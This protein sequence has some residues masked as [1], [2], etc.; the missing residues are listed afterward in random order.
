MELIDMEWKEFQIGKFFNI[1]TGGDVIISKLKGGNIPVIS[2]SISN[3]GVSIYTQPIKGKKLF[4]CNK[5]ISLADRGNFYAYV[6][7]VDFYIG[8]RVKALEIKKE[9]EDVCNK[10]VLMFICPLINAQSVKFSYG[11]NC[12]D[13]TETLKIL[14]P[15]DEANNPDWGFMESYIKRVEK[16]KKE[17]YISYLTGV[18]KTLKH[19]SI[20]A[21]EDKEWE[22]FML[23]ELF[24]FIQ[25]GKR[26]TKGNQKPGLIPYVSS[27]AMNNGVDNFI[28][29]DK[30]VR[31]FKNCLS[32]ANSG[33]VGS[34]FYE[35]YEFVASDHV[36]HLKNENMNKYIYIFIATIVNRLSEKYNFNREINDFRISREKIIL[37]V[38]DDGEPDYEYMEQYVKNMM[39]KRY[40]EYLGW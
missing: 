7:K 5:T 34:C 25:R 37:P 35:P 8:T 19:K 39:L 26:L 38:N 31:K 2:H 9:Y 1:Y 6:Q 3:N 12:C 16:E 15:V 28:S 21:L 27:T 29:N 24:S 22:S 36:T 11:N 18:M 40:K 23:T 4:N 13:S 33:S 30:N 20:P 10:Y 14:L 17:E 32:L